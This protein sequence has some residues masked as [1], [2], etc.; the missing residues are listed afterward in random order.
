MRLHVERALLMSA[1][2]AWAEIPALSPM[3]ADLADDPEIAIEEHEGAHSVAVWKVR[4]RG[5][6]LRWRQEEV[7][8]DESRTISFR[9][10]DGDPRRFDGSWRV[11]SEGPTAGL[12]LD[13]QFEFGLPTV[14]ALIDFTFERAM[15]E[16][17]DGLVAEVAA[18]ASLRTNL[19]SDTGDR[20]RRDG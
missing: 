20:Q 9:L 19:V 11:V 8:D 13:A 1:E 15:N 4:L 17:A 18:S 6:V 7:V 10:L 3:L 14:A 12:V 16:V 5:S 2:D